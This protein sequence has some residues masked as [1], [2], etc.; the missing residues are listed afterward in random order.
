MGE[1]KKSVICGAAVLIFLGAFLPAAAQQT[2]AR[3]TDEHVPT[4]RVFGRW[5]GT[6]TQPGLKPY[7]V[8]MT[9]GANGGATDYPELRCSGELTSAGSDGQYLF[10]IEKI[11]R[12]RLDQGGQ[13]F[14]GSITVVIAKTELAWG[15]VGD[16]DEKTVVAHARLTRR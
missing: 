5:A 6:V 13:C 14:D 2:V 9:L 3:V 7:S 12:G 15:W 1:V 11:S 16:Y 10:F 4:S 8:V